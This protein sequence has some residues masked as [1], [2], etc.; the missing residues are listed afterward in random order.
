MTKENIDKSSA[1]TI[2]TQP[3]PISA[4]QIWKDN[5]KAHTNRLLLVV[6]TGAKYTV[7]QN[8]ATGKISCI[9][10]DHFNRGKTGYFYAGNLRD[11][12]GDEL[13]KILKQ[14]NQGFGEH[15]AKLIGQPQTENAQ[16]G[17]EN[18][19]NAS[20]EERANIRIRWDSA[21]ADMFL[22]ANLRIPR[23][24]RN[25]KLTG[26]ATSNPSAI[27]IWEIHMMFGL[28]DMYNRHADVERVPQISIFVEHDGPEILDNKGFEENGA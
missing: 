17:N 24:L 11:M 1:A 21:I 2:A 25:I 28:I 27:R 19:P 14:L 13:Q 20:D 7:C 9:G 10:K 22:N 23:E 18:K 4:G 3:C 16:N 8:L 26:H 5:R 6:N 12:K 15:L